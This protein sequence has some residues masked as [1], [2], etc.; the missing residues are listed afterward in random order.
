M[1]TPLSMA[2]VVPTDDPA[3]V[4]IRGKIATLARE[5]EAVEVIGAESKEAAVNVLSAI[6]R[7]KT[8]ADRAR[9]GFVTPLKQY[10][11]GV[12]KLFRELLAPIV[13]A[14]QVVRRK[15]LDYDRA[16]KARLAEAEA[17]AER[18]RLR[19]AALLKEATKADTAGEAHVADELLEQAAGAETN[20][21]N[22]AK[23]AAVPPP[24]RT[25]STPFGASATTRRVWTYE[26]VD[27]ALIPREYLIP[28]AM[29]L[30][31]EVNAGLLRELPGLRIFERE[32]LS[33]RS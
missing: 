1:T 31:R 29:R 26:V 16:E 22:A 28:D 6:A 19:S 9:L 17:Q 27:P 11:S 5:C 14:D 18:E 24:P 7:A 3:V 20:A 13:Q 12:D 23:V 32:T 25:F 10:T 8:E 2:L 21:H 33:V 4:A 15:L 30:Q